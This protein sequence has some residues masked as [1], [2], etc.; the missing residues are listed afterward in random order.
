VNFVHKVSKLIPYNLQSQKSGFRVSRTYGEVLILKDSPPVCRGR[1]FHRSIDAACILEKKNE[2]HEY[3][4]KSWGNIKGRK[5]KLL[6]HV[7]ALSVVFLSFSTLARLRFIPHLEMQACNMLY[8]PH[9]I[10]MSLS[11]TASFQTSLKTR[12]NLHKIA[13]KM[14][15]NCLRGWGWQKEGMGDVSIGGSAR[16]WLLGG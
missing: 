13:Y 16:P 1:P 10:F 11:L 5:I 2:K 15:K 7:F 9:Y 3:L 6:K 8:Q 14:S 12:I 4:H